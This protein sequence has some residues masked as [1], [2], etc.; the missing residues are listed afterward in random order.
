M[1]FNRRTA[2]AAGLGAMAA[3]SGSTAAARAA[4]PMT[5]TVTVQGESAVRTNIPVVR[6][7]RAARGR[8]LRL[9]TR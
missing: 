6:D 2:M 4:V 9:R 7:R 3:G 8:H 5:V 1:D